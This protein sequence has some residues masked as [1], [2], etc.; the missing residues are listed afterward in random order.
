VE[1]LENATPPGTKAE[2][3]VKASFAPH[4]WTFACVICST[5]RI[6][7][8]YSFNKVVQHPDYCKVLD[9]SG[10]LQCQQQCAT[11]VKGS[12]SVQH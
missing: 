12:I 3:R 1:A 8:H 11:F 2:P 5:G 4:A 6:S 9:R 7:R 10:Y